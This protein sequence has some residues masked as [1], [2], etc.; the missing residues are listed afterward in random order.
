[1]FSYGWYYV[2]KLTFYGRNISV[3]YKD[4]GR[5]AVNTFRFGYKT[6]SVINV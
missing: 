2:L 5:T 3:L 4:S 1:M 6:Q